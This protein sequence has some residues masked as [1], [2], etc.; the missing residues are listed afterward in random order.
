[1][2]DIRSFKAKD[3]KYLENRITGVFTLFSRYFIIL[4]RA[5]VLLIQWS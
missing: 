3:I 5:S 4:K 1:M 2:S